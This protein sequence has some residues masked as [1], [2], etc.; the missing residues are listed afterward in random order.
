MVLV[1]VAH[2]IWFIK[3][4]LPLAGLPEIQKRGASV[5]S[6][7]ANDEVHTQ[8]N[9]ASLVCMLARCWRRSN[10]PPKSILSEKAKEIGQQRQL[11]AFPTLTV[12]QTASS[13]TDLL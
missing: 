6:Q 1:L 11:K 5:F 2:A 7:S 4:D 9:V 8:S 13:F 3:V 10:L 12:P